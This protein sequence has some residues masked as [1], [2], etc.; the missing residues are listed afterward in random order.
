[1]CKRH[2]RELLPIRAIFDH[3]SP[4]ARRMRNRIDAEAEEQA[5]RL[6][7][8]KEERERAAD[9]DDDDVAAA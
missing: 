7:M 5:L 9:M 3:L 2:A 6:E 8:A 4:D 1:M